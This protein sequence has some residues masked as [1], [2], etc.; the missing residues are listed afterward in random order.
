MTDP[1]R[2]NIAIDSELLRAVEQ[3]TARGQSVTRFIEISVAEA[4]RKQFLA[5]GLESGRRARWS[6]RYVSVEEALGRLTEILN[7][8][9]EGER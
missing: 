6:G 1:N 5:K 8:R 9:T 2:T 3:V 7:D 4:V